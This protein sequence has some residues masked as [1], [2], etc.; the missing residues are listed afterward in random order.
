M[1]MRSRSRSGRGRNLSDVG[2]ARTRSGV[3]AEIERHG[4]LVYM[5]CT[6]LCLL[7]L[8]EPLFEWNGRL[9]GGVGGTGVIYLTHLDTEDRFLSCCRPV[10]TEP[11]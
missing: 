2:A 5:Y 6:L 8:L 10:V 9:V 7:A 4:I 3:W 11:S 1:R